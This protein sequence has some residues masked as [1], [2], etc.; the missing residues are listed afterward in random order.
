MAKD[1]INF[2]KKDGTKARKDRKG[3]YYYMKKL[4]QKEEAR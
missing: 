3:L 1:S 4:K 2:K